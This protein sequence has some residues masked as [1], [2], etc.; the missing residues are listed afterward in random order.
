MEV[1]RCVN[2]MIR[3][4]GESEVGEAYEKNRQSMK[5]NIQVCIEHSHAV[6]KEVIT[7][8]YLASI[9]LDPSQPLPDPILNRV[10]YL[11]A[12]GIVKN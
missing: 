8:L 6:S 3:Y 4:I 10:H 11:H 12:C 5:K 7:Q 9:Y 2:F 1:L